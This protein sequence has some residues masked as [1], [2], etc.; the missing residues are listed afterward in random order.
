MAQRVIH[1]DRVHVDVEPVL[2][3]QLDETT[4]VVDVSMGEERAT[5]V[6]G[7]AADPFDGLDDLG[8]LARITAVDERQLAVLLQQHPV[9]DVG[10]DEMRC[11]RIAVDPGDRHRSRGT[12]RES[13]HRHFRTTRTN[14]PRSVTSKR[15]SSNTAGSNVTV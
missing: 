1:L 9:H 7:L 13:H 14:G 3:L 6:L 5:Y 2:R 4:Q 15:G 12:E 10:G 11:R 8:G